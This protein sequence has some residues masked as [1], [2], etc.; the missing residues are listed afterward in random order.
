MPLLRDPGIFERMF[1][2]PVYKPGPRKTSPPQAVTG[3]HAPY[4][5]RDRTTLN[6]RSPAPLAAPLSH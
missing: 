3:N 2:C 1:R 5:N 4:V 6:E